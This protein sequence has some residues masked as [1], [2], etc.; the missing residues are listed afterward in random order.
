MVYEHAGIGRESL[1]NA[2]SVLL[3][4][5]F[6][7]LYR[8]T[9]K[10]WIVALLPTAFVLLLWIGGRSRKAPYRAHSM[11]TLWY[12]AM[13]NF[14][15]VFSLF[16]FTSIGAAS[17]LG[18]VYLMIG[19]GTVAAPMAAAVKRLAPESTE[20][21]RRVPTGTVVNESTAH[22]FAA[23]LPAVSYLPS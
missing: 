8:Q 21:N 14:L 15:Y 12:G 13:T 10:G 22:R 9:A 7:R 16:Y 18:T 23:R 2:M 6:V 4:T 3:F 1:A 17:G 20:Q 5:F 19:A 11:R